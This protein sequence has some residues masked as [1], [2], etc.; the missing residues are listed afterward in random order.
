MNAEKQKEELKQAYY[1]LFQT[2]DGK[3]VK[4]DLERLCCVRHTSVSSE[5]EPNALSVLFNE[6]KRRVFLHI[7]FM[8]NIEVDK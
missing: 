6:G 8:T 5:R 1:R 2:D 7:Q 4:A 3:K